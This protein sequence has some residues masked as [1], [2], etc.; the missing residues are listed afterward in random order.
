MKEETR[1]FEKFERNEKWFST[2]FDDLEENYMNKF[3]A[4]LEPNK[5]IADENLENLLTKLEIEDVDISS[6]FI[7]AIS[8]RGTAS[9]L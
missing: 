8:P 5:L 9:I 3:I 7:T 4:V 1:I 2:H 6:V